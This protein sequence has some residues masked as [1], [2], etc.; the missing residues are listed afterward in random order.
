MKLAFQYL[1]H[2]MASKRSWLIL[3]IWIIYPLNTLFGADTLS[4]TSDPTTE[5]TIYAL[6]RNIFS[7]YTVT[8][9]TIPFFLLLIEHH[10]V[11]F[12]DHKVLLRHG[13]YSHWWLKRLGFL[14]LDCI[15]YT[16]F[17]NVLVIFSI[18]INSQTSSV[19][20]SFILAILKV[21]TFQLLGYLFL[22]KA[23]T[24]ATYMTGRNLIGFIISYSI[25]IA[26]FILFQIQSDIQLL[27]PQMYFLSSASIGEYL[28]RNFA[29]ICIYLVSLLCI[30]NL[31]GYMLCSSK[32]VLGGTSH[33][34]E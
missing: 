25:V 19:T 21:S 31:V 12:D 34:Y 29:V 33:A 28:D 16:A 18:C 14:C 15:L 30:V 22:G 26:D 3:L 10:S 27:I 4:K 11:F 32:D 20:W 2:L 1:R 9:M 17:T 13:S 24:V 5:T 8:F 23:Y 6:Y 7:F